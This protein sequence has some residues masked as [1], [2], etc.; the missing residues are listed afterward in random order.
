MST[1]N[2]EFKQFV[3]DRLQE[4]G[5]VS[6]FYIRLNHRFSFF[7]L[8]NTAEDLQLTFKDPKAEF[9]YKLRGGDSLLVQ[10]LREWEDESG[11]TVFSLN[12]QEYLDEQA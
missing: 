9:V 6:Q 7:I 4:I 12:L 3:S 10:W 5:I 1:P 8:S 11:E 2:Q